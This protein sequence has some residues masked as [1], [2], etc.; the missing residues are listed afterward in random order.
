MTEKHNWPQIIRELASVG[1]GINR[2]KTL[3]GKQWGQIDRWRHGIEPKHST[4]EYLL[5]LHK[6]HVKA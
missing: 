1:I 5:K 3:T 6:E 4:G 2:L